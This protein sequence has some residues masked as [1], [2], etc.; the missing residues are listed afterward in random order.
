MV[1]LLDVLDA[2]VHPGAGTFSREHADYVLSLDLPDAV[3]D[4]CDDL[5]LKAQDG[6]LTPEETAELDHY[7][8]ADAMLTV[9]KSKARRSLS[10]PDLGNHRT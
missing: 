6:A 4:R 3:K 5:S 8:S 10:T 1:A 2:V 9:M 7:I